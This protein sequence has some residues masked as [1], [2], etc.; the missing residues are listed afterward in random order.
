MED[1]DKANDLHKMGGLVPLHW[2]LQHRAGHEGIAMWTLFTLGTAAAH[3]P[4]VQLQMLEQG[5]LVSLVPLLRI[6]TPAAV[7]GKVCSRAAG[8]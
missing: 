2:L 1:V 8:C 7:L 5:V 3:N 4:K 6:D